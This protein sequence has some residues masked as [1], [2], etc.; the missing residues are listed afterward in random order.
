MRR[1]FVIL[2]ATG[3]L[4]LAACGGGSGGGSGSGADPTQ[5]TAVT[6]PTG[7]SGAITDPINRAKTVVGQQNE[8]LRQEE[9]RTGSGDPTSP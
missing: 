4:G 9:Q 7:G 5:P 8:Q 6:T 1:T 2:I 3:I